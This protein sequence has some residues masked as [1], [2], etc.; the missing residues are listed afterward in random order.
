MQLIYGTLLRTE[1]KKMLS[2]PHVVVV[3]ALASN[4]HQCTCD[5][6]LQDGTFAIANMF[7]Q[8]SM[9][10]MYRLVQ[11]QWCKCWTWDGTEVESIGVQGTW[12]V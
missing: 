1:S 12:G 5:N 2:T 11:K 10:S 3:V 9:Q 6:I 7:V 4:L 8:H